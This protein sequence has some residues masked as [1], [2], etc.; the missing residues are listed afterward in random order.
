M[1]ISQ[2]EGYFKES[3]IH[4]LEEPML[5]QL[6]VNESFKKKIVPVLRQ[7]SCQNSI[8]FCTELSKTQFSLRASLTILLNL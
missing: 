1:P 3:L 8:N 5:F 4:L 2:T 7:S 6:A